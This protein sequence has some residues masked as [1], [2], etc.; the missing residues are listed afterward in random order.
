MNGQYSIFDVGSKQRP[1][2]YDFQRSIGQR[3]EM[4]NGVKGT[5]TDI[6][7]YYTDVLGDDGVLYAGTPTTCY[8]EEEG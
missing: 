6:K 8:P 5:I 4:M 1:C 7:P 3:V 2:D